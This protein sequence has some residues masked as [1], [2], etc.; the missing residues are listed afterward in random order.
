MKKSK[1][2]F[3]ILI[4]CIAKAS[5]F[6]E[7]VNFFW[8]F[9]EAGL[10][11]DLSNHNFDISGPEFTLKTTNN[12]FG[13]S[14]TTIKGR[15]DLL[16]DDNIDDDFSADIGELGIFW[17]PLNINK[18]SMFGP[19]I[20]TGFHL[21]NQNNFYLRTGL[22]FSWSYKDPDYNNFLIPAFSIINAEVGYSI[23][24]NSF[25]AQFSTDVSILVM[26]LI[27]GIKG[28]YEDNQEEQYNRNPVNQY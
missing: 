24:D 27:E 25:Y 14:L 2:I 1:I 21:A 28:E 9:G 6:S 19:R 22:A 7:G 5:L 23:I 13:I 10:S 8:T 4:F 12:N 17:S 18:Y 15:F 11:T 26:A 3:L 20:S 16:E